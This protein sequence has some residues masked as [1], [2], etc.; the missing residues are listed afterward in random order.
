MALVQVLRAHLA[1][2][3]PHVP[4]SSL[5]CETMHH[6]A[7]SL[8]GGMLTRLRVTQTPH[9]EGNRRLVFGESRLDA[10]GATQRLVIDAVSADGRTVYLPAGYV[11]VMSP[12]VYR[13]RSKVPHEGV[14]CVVCVPSV[15]RPFDCTAQ[16][17]QIEARHSPPEVR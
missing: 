3:A 14:K 6:W 13:V 9:F 8:L 1:Q 17:T 10:V 7:A 11:H 16:V 5:V 12:G 15:E 2:S 4:P